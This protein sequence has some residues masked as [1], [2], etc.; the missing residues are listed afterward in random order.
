MRWPTLPQAVK[1]PRVD[2]I[3][4]QVPI[5]DARRALEAM[6]AGLR[7]SPP[8]SFMDDWEESVTEGERLLEEFRKKS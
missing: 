6:L 1:L 2:D 3:P 8:D 4:P 5:I 7:S